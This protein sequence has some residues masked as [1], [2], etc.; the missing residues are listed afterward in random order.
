MKHDKD[1]GLRADKIVDQL[2]AYI[3]ASDLS[4]F[5]DYW[6]YLS[7]NFFSRLDQRYSV[8]VR[9]L[10]VSLLKLYLVTA[11]MYNRKDQIR[12][13]FEKLS[14][15]LQNQQEF[16][17]WFV[18]ILLNFDHDYRQMKTLQEENDMLKEKLLQGGQGMDKKGLESRS[19]KSGIVMASQAVPELIYDFSGLAKETETVT[20]KQKSSRRFP[21]TL[22]SPLM[23]RSK[24]EMPADNTSPPLNSYKLQQKH[25]AVTL[26]P[27]SRSFNQSFNN[28]TSTI[29]APVERPVLQPSVS[30]PGSSLIKKFPGMGS[31]SSAHRGQSVVRQ[32]SSSNLELQQVVL[33]GGQQTSIEHEIVASGHTKG[34]KELISFPPYNSPQSELSASQALGDEKLL[35]EKD[36]SARPLSPV[37]VPFDVEETA[38]MLA[39]GSDQELQCIDV[40]RLQQTG[41][42][43]GASCPFLRLN[44]DV[45]KEHQSSICCSRFS[46]SGQHVASLDMDG[47]VKVWSWS[48]QPSTTATVMSR[49]PFLSLDW[50][51][52][53]DRWLLLGN[54]NGCIRLFDTREL[55]TFGEVTV[56]PPFLSVRHLT[57]CPAS[58]RFASSL[59]T[60]G[61]V[62]SKKSESGRIACWD[63][64]TLKHVQ[65]LTVEP[66]PV[67]INCCVYNFTGQTLLLGGSDG[68]V[69]L[70][71]TSQGRCVSS[72]NAHKSP[73]Q[74][75]YYGHRES[76]FF[77]MG[78]DNKLSEWSLNNPKEPLRQ[79]L[80]KSGD[81]SAGLT[82]KQ[83]SSSAAPVSQL[84]SLSKNKSYLL[85]FIKNKGVVCKV[86]EDK[87]NFYALMDLSCHEDLVTTVDWSQCADTDVCLTGTKDGQINICT[88]LYH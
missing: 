62:P 60:I 74:T 27:D 1:K 8:S 14:S 63:L 3:N 31:P 7:Q 69:R 53:S 70:F 64:K 25:K 65:Y 80:V 66:E 15:D 19:A 20:A 33:M 18:P 82:K 38:E 73:V 58:M 28:C 48:P 86:P 51:S 5:R 11:Q 79:I 16:K 36:K 76:T 12:E 54:N 68:V 4:H 41:E 52:K 50:A 44:E 85:T 24:Y 88:L 30:F 35:L 46:L 42:K 55:K 56:E 59:V 72:W 77:S 78:L 87:T 83:M 2:L 17:E 67:A 32:D 39:A 21:I 6:L 37:Q 47:I 26:Q 71:D 43:S 10:E 34:G 29:P 9:K 57:T 22:A 84:F 49:S 81:H 45:Y 13:V 40:L 75:L 61:T 23:R